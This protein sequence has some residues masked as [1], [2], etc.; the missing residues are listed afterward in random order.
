MNKEEA[1]KALIN[2]VKKADEFEDEDSFVTYLHTLSKETIL[3][4]IDKDLGCLD[5]Q[6]K[7]KG[8][9]KKKSR[10]RLV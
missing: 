3:A 9:A 6:L 2:N 7:E 5:K 8:K 1:I 10:K 4:L